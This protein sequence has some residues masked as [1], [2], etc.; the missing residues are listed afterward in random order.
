[1]TV[2]SS[3]GA[4]VVAVDMIESSCVGLS[5]CV[6]AA[7]GSPVVPV[8]SWHAHR[9]RPGAAAHIRRYA[10]LREGPRVDAATRICVAASA[11][12]DGSGEP[13]RHGVGDRLGAAT[14]AE[15]AV[16]VGEVG[17]HGAGTDEEG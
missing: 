2:S 3:V 13:M 7:P 5:T 1:M 14:D 10:Q 9:M 4:M 16:E 12:R 11:G 8:R 17:L 6:V 15:L